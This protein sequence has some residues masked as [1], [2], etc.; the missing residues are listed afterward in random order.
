M[1]WSC[2]V[3]MVWFCV[4]Q[5]PPRHLYGRP[6]CIHWAAAAAADIKGFSQFS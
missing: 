2:M 1:V 6:P 4:Y 3:H 5:W